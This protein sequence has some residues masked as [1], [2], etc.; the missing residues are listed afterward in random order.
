M[1][2]WDKLGIEIMKNKKLESLFKYLYEDLSKSNI[3]DVE[4]NKIL[5]FIYGFGIDNEKVE[6]LKTFK[7]SIYETEIQKSLNESE[8]SERNNDIIKKIGNIHNTKIDSGKIIEIIREAWKQQKFLIN[9]L[10]N[11]IQKIKYLV[12]YEA[13]PSKIDYTNN[14]HVGDF[15]LNE[16]SL[17]PYK[18]AIINAFK[19]ENGKSLNNT[20]ISN[21]AY[22]I[23]I[24]PVPIPFNPII[25]NKWA[26]SYI[27]KIEDKQITVHL[28][29]KAIENF[30]NSFESNCKFDKNLKIAIGMPRNT[31]AALYD[32]YSSNVF[33]VYR[34]K[35]LVTIENEERPSFLFKIDLT[36]T[37][38]ILAKSKHK[39]LK[40]VNL[41]LFK[42]CFVD[43]SGQPNS[44]LLKIALE[45]PPFEK[46]S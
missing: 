37:N 23:D 4:I 12:I 29:E 8:P 28:F 9:E 31:A 33:F 41:P 19:K 7:A 25:R 16:N 34:D 46:I 6:W 32:Y 26:T 22:F 17:S 14:L 30:V 38:C 11:N 39:D 15:I 40:G 18:H 36:Q 42:T 45:I 2:K 21:E 27:F 13:P 43:T 1:I 3:K 20:L 35:N 44:L 5:N 24:I 10:N